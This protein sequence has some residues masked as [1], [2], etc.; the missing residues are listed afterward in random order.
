MGRVAGVP[1]RHQHAAGLAVL[2]SS[3][4]RIPPVDLN[5]RGSGPYCCSLLPPRPDCVGHAYLS[6]FHFVIFCNKLF[7]IFVCQREP[8]KASLRLLI[9]TFLCLNVCAWLEDA[10][11]CEKEKHRAK[12]EYR[13]SEYD[14]SNQAKVVAPHINKKLLNIIICARGERGF[15]SHR[16]HAR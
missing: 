12:T 4:R 9:R 8:L 11:K 6:I 5:Y 3:R 7:I 14:C 2:L 16:S 13:T 15:D 10:S 1:S